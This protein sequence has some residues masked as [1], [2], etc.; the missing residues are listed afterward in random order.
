[1]TSM[2]KFFKIGCLGIIIIA[3]LL[4]IIAIV[5]GG[6]EEN[7]STGTNSDAKT[8]ET[9]KADDGTKTIDA[10]SQQVTAQGL[11]VGLGDVKIK[12]NKIQ[13]GINAQNTTDGVLQFY[14]DQG[15]AVIGDIQLDANMFLTDGDVSG[16]IQGG[17]KK[18]GVL[19]FLAPEGRTIDVNSV[20]EI[21]LILGDVTTEDF[22]NSEDVSFTIPVK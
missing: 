7:V 16:D 11:K 6:D 3:V 8:T 5:S 20:K 9:Q 2:K 21:K 22:M 12:E 1:M 13:V 10:S 17:V 18:E 4:V 15:S 14:P 19:E